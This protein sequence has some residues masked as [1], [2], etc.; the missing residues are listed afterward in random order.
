MT[1]LLNFLDHTVI[2]SFIISFIQLKPRRVRPDHD[3]PFGMYAEQFFYDD[4]T[5]NDDETD[6]VCINTTY[7]AIFP[8]KE[9]YNKMSTY[10]YLPSNTVFH[11]REKNI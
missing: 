11:L 8:G 5:E 7:F 9:A 4:E 2:L 1:R 6:P 3:F 10:V